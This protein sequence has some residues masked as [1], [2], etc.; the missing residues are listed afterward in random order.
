MY[1]YLWGYTRA[2][3]ELMNHDAPITVYKASKK[4]HSAGD[5]P[6]PE[7]CHMAVLKWKLRRAK[8]K[9]NIGSVL[10]DIQQ[11]NGNKDNNEKIGGPDRE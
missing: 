2:Q 4:K 7:K 5:K 1:E 9:F 10:K 6:D 3:I 8:R 11:Q